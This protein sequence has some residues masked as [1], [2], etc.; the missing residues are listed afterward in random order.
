M[1]SIFGKT[2]V[3]KNMSPKFYELAKTFILYSEITPQRSRALVP[4]KKTNFTFSLH[5]CSSDIS[6]L[7]R[8]NKKKRFGVRLGVVLSNFESTIVLFRN[9]IWFF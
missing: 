6:M 7:Y 1:T 9:I 3:N 5:T 4:K 8:F 2:Y